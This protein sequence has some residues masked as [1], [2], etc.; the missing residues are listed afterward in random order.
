[1]PPFTNF[2]GLYARW[3]ERGGPRR[4]EPPFFLPPRWVRAERKIQRDTPLNFVMTA[5]IVGGNSGSPVINRA[6]ELVGLIFDGNLQSL[7]S[8]YAYDDRQGR[9]IAVDVRAMIESLRKVYGANAL[10][11]ELVGR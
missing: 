7:G 9:T 6:G 10:A 2:A 4:E 11:D 3:R 5:D 1:M 8:S